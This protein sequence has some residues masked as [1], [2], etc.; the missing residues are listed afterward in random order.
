MKCEK[1]RERG[2]EDVE[3]KAEN[4]QRNENVRFKVC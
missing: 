1:R 3:T 4:K 2:R